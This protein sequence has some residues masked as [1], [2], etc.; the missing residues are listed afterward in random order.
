MAIPSTCPPSS[1]PVVMGTNG[2]VST[3]HPLASLAERLIDGV[4]RMGGLLTAE[5][6]AGYRAQWVKPISTR[7][8]EY[9]VFTHPPNSSAFQVLETLNVV[10]GFNRDEL[11][12]RDPR[13]L[14]LLMESVKL[15]VTDRIRYAGDPDYVDVPLKG[16]LSKAY[17]AE[18]RKRI[19]PERAAPSPASTTPA[20]RRKGL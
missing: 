2:M 14:H 11:V 12:H 9:E 13:T 4:Q 10:E 20:L 19:D 7:Y 3:G 16:L 18:Q 1:R 5:D 6:L 17:A 8:R 15:C